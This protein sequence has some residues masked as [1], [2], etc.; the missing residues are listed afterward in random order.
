[1]ANHEG[2]YNAS[3][4]VLDALE[5]NGQIVFRY[6][7]NPNGSVRD[8]AGI[9]NGRRNVLGMMPHPERAAEEV[10]GSADGRALFESVFDALSRGA[11]G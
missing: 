8:I 9:V 5:R 1:V 11:V 6:V 3:D 7:D 10:L 2:R 4:E